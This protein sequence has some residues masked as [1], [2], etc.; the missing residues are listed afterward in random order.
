MNKHYQRNCISPLPH[1]SPRRSQ[2]DE[3]IYN[4]PTATR[5]FGHPL[6]RRD[7]ERFIIQDTPTTAEPW[8][9]K[10]HV[11]HLVGFSAK[12]RGLLRRKPTIPR[13]W[14]DKARSQKMHGRLV[15][16]SSIQT[17]KEDS[18]DKKKA[19]GLIPSLSRTRGPE[20][21]Y[22]PTVPLKETKELIPHAIVSGSSSTSSSRMTL[23]PE[24]PIPEP[25]KAEKEYVPASEIKREWRYDLIPSQDYSDDEECVV[26]RP[27]TIR[28]TDQSDIDTY[29]I[30]E[31]ELRRLLNTVRF[32]KKKVVVSEGLHDCYKE[33]EEK[34]LETL[35]SDYGPDDLQEALIHI[36]RIIF[37]DID[38]ARF[39]ESIRPIRNRL[40]EIANS[41][42]RRSLE[43]VME[44]NP[45]ALLLY[46][47][48]ILLVLF[49][50]ME[51]IYGDISTSHALYLWES[52]VEWELY[53]IGFKAQQSS[54]VSKYDIHAIFSNLMLRAKNLHRLGLP[55]H[56]LAKQNAGQ[57]VWIQDIE[58]AWVV[59]QVD[60][61]M[62]AGLI[63][64]YSGDLYAKWHY[65]VNDPKVLE[66]AGKLALQSDWRK[67]VFIT[68]VGMHKVLWMFVERD[69]GSELSPFVLEYK[70]P[71][72]GQLTVPWIKLSDPWKVP[73]LDRG[74]LIKPVQDDDD[75]SEELVDAYLKKI[76]TFQE[77]EVVK[78]T[79]E[80]GVDVGPKMYQLDFKDIDDDSIVE[81]LTFKDTDKVVRVLRHIITTGKPFRTPSGKLLLWKYTTD[82]KYD[83]SDD[84]AKKITEK[85]SVSFL[86][87]L[88][89]RKSFLPDYFT[90][91]TTC[92]ELLNATN[93]P[94][95]KLIVSRSRKRFKVELEGLPSTSGLKKIERL[96]LGIY[97]VGLFVECEQLIDVENQTRHKMS[98]SIEN[99]LAESYIPDMNDFPRFHKVLEAL[100]E[101]KNQDYDPGI[102]DDGHITEEAYIEYSEIEVFA[103][104]EEIESS[105]KEDTV[106]TYEIQDDE[107][108]VKL[109]R[110]TTREDSVGGEVIFVVL[111]S[112]SKTHN[113]PVT[114]HFHSIR[115]IG[116]MSKDKFVSDVESRLSEYNL[117][118]NDLNRVVKESI[119]IMGREKLLNRT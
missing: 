41:D 112:G 37:Q 72:K 58:S 84:T 31:R 95:V 100:I 15:T 35:L 66:K 13:G 21:S 23:R 107:S 118:E 89:K 68:K 19:L 47:N 34:C 52:V 18:M 24:L 119:V 62:V 12:F 43:E 111:K 10:I 117:T 51:K 5:S 88:I 73:T 56:A 46:G 79:C 92:E 55:K 48:N 86:K 45:D 6:P 99:I 80:I 76:V 74:S 14:G 33:I 64:D 103:D 77:K 22:I 16:L 110:V 116:R 39:W 109:D 65:C 114:H 20:E 85:V 32:L 113:I 69:A 75:D 28:T 3:I 60:D 49:A 40:F 91:P 87:L 57:I 25:N 93:G 63:E 7:D 11:P 44:E 71:K 4:A 105:S 59:F 1:D 90:Y 42:N 104:D 98:V 8:S 70:I 81:T 29:Q 102:V 83:W 17:N 2:V 36:A 67:P 94:D 61:Q 54:V 50:V 96:E 82:V 53:Q 106:D 9:S 97:D 108:I 38:R 115:E 78:V 26:R 27:P 101:S 30:R